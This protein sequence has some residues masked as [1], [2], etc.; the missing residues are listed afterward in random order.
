MTETHAVPVIDAKMRCDVCLSGRDIA[1]VA[2]SVTGAISF[3]YCRR[4]L[5]KQA[6]PEW[7][8]EYLYSDVGHDGE[9]LADWVSSLST[10]KNGG[11][12]TWD[13]WV[14]WRRKWPRRLK[15]AIIRFW[16]RNILHDPYA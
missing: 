2:A 12:W 7:T 16:R 13:E 4:C 11:Y 15:H 10:Y 3:C 8:F 14:A 9:G 1:G 5:N 6:E